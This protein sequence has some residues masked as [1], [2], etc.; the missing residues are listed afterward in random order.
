MRP[1]DPAATPLRGSRVGLGAVAL[2]RAAVGVFAVVASSLILALGFT[3]PRQPGI[4]EAGVYNAIYTWVHTGRMAFPIYGM[5]DSFGIHPHTHYAVVGSLMRLGLDLYH[6]E[7]VP[8]VGMSLL[9]IVLVMTGRFPAVVKLGLIMGLYATVAHAAFLL[10]DHAFSVRPE[11]HLSVAW[12]AGLVALE[13]GRLASWHSGRLFLGSFLVTYASGLQNYASLGFLGV[14]VY[15]VWS[16]RDLGWSRARKQLLA[17]VAGGVLF[18]VPYL[19]LYVFP[20]LPMIRNNIAWG[21][22]YAT[23]WSG[24]WGEYFSVHDAWVRALLPKLDSL[25]FTVG[26]VV[27]VL[28][29]GVPLFFAAPLFLLVP[30]S[31]RGLALAGLPVPIL[32]FLTLPKSQYFISEYV[33]YLAGFWAAL[34]TGVTW[35]SRRLLPARLRPLT[36]VVMTTVLALGAFYGSPSFHRPGL[37]LLGPPHEQDVARAAGREILGR[38]AVVGSRHLAWYLSGAAEWF[39]LEPVLT[40]PKDI[41]S[42]DVRTFLSQFDAV[43]DYGAASSHTQNGVTLSSLYADGQLHLR[44]F[45]LGQRIGGLSYLLF[46][47]GSDRPVMGYLLRDDV[48]Y[49]FDEHPAGEHVLSTVLAPLNQPPTLQLSWFRDVNTLWLPTTGRPEAQGISTAVL[50]RSE[51]ASHLAGLGADRTPLGAVAGDLTPVDARDLL[52]RSRR[53]DRAIRFLSHPQESKLREFLE[54]PTVVS[55][56][57]RR[58][59]SPLLAAGLARPETAIG[60]APYGGQAAHAPASAFDDDSA[61]VWA[62]NLAGSSVRGQAFI[63]QDFGPTGAREVRSITLEQSP[64]LDSTVDSVLVQYS[65]D[66]VSWVPVAVVHLTPGAQRHAFEIPP[67]GPHRAWSLLAN[68]EPATDRTWVVAEVKFFESGRPSARR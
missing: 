16:L 40:E 7:A 17:L 41:S 28:S 65:D 6:A 26:P 36:P 21:T 25:L 1:S 8:V 31:T 37:D 63:G 15:L 5:F 51:Y 24:K 50:P 61:T 39:R 34:L 29:V 60:F 67:L 9:A 27:P 30:R 48:L 52:A 18:G 38:D 2:E 23:P 57:P 45:Y 53:D 47:V 49:R 55:D 62:P 56:E 46:D 19:W 11:L 35:L 68:G 32:I 43:A 64:S 4:E 33:Y 3:T 66:G 13:S 20:N 42:L 22:T 59:A 12:F 10:P 14:V 58:P 54:R 44:G